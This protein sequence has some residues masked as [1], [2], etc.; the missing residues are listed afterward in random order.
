[1]Q[2]FALFLGLL[3][4]QCSIFGQV[5][6]GT[7]TPN[8]KSILDISSHTKGLLVPRMTGSERN[9]LY[10]NADDIGMTVYQTDVP[11]APY[12]PSPK[13]FY[14]FDGSTWTAPLLNGSVNGETL[15]WDGNK[16]VATT[17]LFNQGG[18]IGIGTTTPKTQLHINSGQA[19][20]T[21]LQFTNTNTG[22][23]TLDGLVLGITLANQDA[24]LLQ[25]ENRSLWFGTNGTERLRIDSTGKVGINKSNPSATLDV[26]GTVKL[27]STGTTL[28]GI[29]RYSGM[30]DIPL[31]LSNSEST[32]DV[33]IPNVIPSGTVQVSPSE[34]LSQVMIEYARVSDYS[35]VEIKF[36][37]LSMLPADPAAI[38][39]YITVIQ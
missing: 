1:M 35:H 24:H 30:I 8:T 4:C 7:V 33:A 15:R 18:S 2:K 36:M 6:I 29:I 9:T 14:T 19:T 23:N 3:A 11:I 20:T 5:G 17:N 13:G 16:W 26:N 38:I 27:G 12:S 10:L 39:Y 25:Q 22:P 28:T 31:M 32:Y 21:R 37:N 34:S